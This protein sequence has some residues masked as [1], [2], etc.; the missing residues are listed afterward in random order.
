MRTMLVGERDCGK[1][2]M[3]LSAEDEYLKWQQRNF[4]E[5][6]RVGV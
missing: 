2:S 5:T 3:N 4:G 6:E 1:Y